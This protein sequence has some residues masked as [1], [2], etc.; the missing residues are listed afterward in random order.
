M[1]DYSRGAIARR[2]PMRDLRRKQRRGKLLG[3]L[4]LLLLLVSILPLG[5]FVAG[6]LEGGG[7]RPDPS[8][9]APHP[10]DPGDLSVL[11][12]ADGAPVEG[13]VLLVGGAPAKG[14]RFGTVRF[15]GGRPALARVALLDPLG[16]VIAES[17][18]DASG[19]YALP[20]DARA[21]AVC[22]TAP[23]FAP[24]IAEEG[25]LLLGAGVELRGRLLGTSGGTIEVYA[26]VAGADRPL[27]T[28]AVWS[29]GEDGAFAGH[30]PPGARAV[31]VR[32][33]MPFALR[34]GE[35]E[36]PRVVRAGGRVLAA[37]GEGVA[38]AEVLLR[39]LLGEDFP[40]PMP[41]L[42]VVT[43]AD[44][45]FARERVAAGAWA[46][47]ARAPGY[48]AGLLPEVD[49]GSGP[50]EI[51]LE[52]GFAVGGRVLDVAGRPVAGAE[53]IALPIVEDARS[54]VR[55]RSGEDG[56]FR[57]DGLPGHAVRLRVES[58]RHHPTTIE[59]IGP[60]SELRILLQPR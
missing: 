38:G 58:S 22:A 35:I 31:A 45:S 16:A 59:S 44:G 4:A 60:R 27:V 29:V 50:V 39:P 10:D 18:T 17:E 41:P 20:D 21:A 9:P 14:G 52:P 32:D 47:E 8:R 55:A 3:A 43:G 33:G 57:L 37:N 2:I 25:D 53:L 30:L 26:L 28:R 40:P 54:P 23:G 6:I 46:V 24:A 42:R 1:V 34:E 11:A 15:R 51:V 12:A 56:A 36:L 48:A 49:F 13:A 19:R 7:A 5:G